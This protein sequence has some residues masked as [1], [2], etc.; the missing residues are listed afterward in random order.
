MPFTKEG[1]VKKGRPKGTLTTGFT[2][3]TDE[4]KK[5]YKS[6]VV[7]KHRAKS[8]PS[9]SATKSSAS[10]PS[11]T[12]RRRTLLQNISPATTEEA[13]QPSSS[14]QG[15]P[16]ISGEKAMTPNTRRGR[17][18]SQ[19]KTRR[20]K[21]KVSSIRS[22]ISKSLWQKDK[23]ENNKLADEYDSS[24]DEGNDDD[25]SDH[26]LSSDDNA[27][28]DSDAQTLHTPPASNENNTHIPAVDSD[29]PGT[30]SSANMKNSVGHAPSTIYRHRSSLRGCLTFNAVDN[31]RILM[32]YVSRFLFITS[33]SDELNKIVIADGHLNERQIRY[34]VKKLND[35]IICPT[36]NDVKLL[37]K[38][39]L[40]LLLEHP[41]IERLFIVAS[42]NIEE[43]LPHSLTVLRKAKTIANDLVTSRSNVKDSIRKTGI[44]FV[45]EV[46]QQCSLS[47]KNARDI[48]TLANA[49]SCSWRFAKKVLNAIESGDTEDLYTRQMKYNA[50]KASEWP[51]EICKFVLSENNSRSVPGQEQVSVR[52]GYRLPKYILLHSR[53]S[54]ADAFKQ[55]F[56][57]CP[58]SA[59]TIMREFPQNA[60]TATTRDLE[61]NTCPVHANARRLINAINKTLVKQKSVDRLPSSCRDLA[62]LTMC[63]SNVNPSKPLSWKSDC[64]RGT[65]KNCPDKLPLSLPTGIQNVEVKYSQWRS[66]K[67]TYTK[68]KKGKVVSIE[69]SVFSLYPETC[70]VQDALL[71]LEK[72]CKPL[73]LHIYTAHRQWNAHNQFRENLDMFTIITIEDYQMNLEVV[74]KENPTS[75]AYSTNKMTVAIYPICVEYRNSDGTISK[76]A[77]TFISDDKDH[78][79]QQVQQFERRMFQIVRERLGR[80]I[81]NWIRFSDGCG[82]QFKSGF[83]AADIFDAPT[84]FDI[85]T[86]AFNFFASHEGKSASDS[87]GS[88]VKCAFVRGMLKNEQGV[89]NID[90]IL[91]VILSETKLS[92]K[93]FDHFIVEKFGRFQKKLP[94]PEDTVK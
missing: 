74:Y 27:V 58:Y 88:I 34:R 22:K 50:I 39:W 9:L 94:L 16:P 13:D 80:P 49:T 7:R 66:E 37:V 31:L 26:D 19:Q 85:N 15:R 61:R 12:K 5:K 21:A 2:D 6:E 67:K 33:F 53:K 42:V 69:K 8:V 1:K 73:R 59:S 38:Y 20:H 51:E 92:T 43:Y 70:S 71:K 18:R 10:N 77:I 52:Y 32:S 24:S 90:D 63:K 11:P 54:I 65:C 47:T 72:M 30:S 68:E 86:V 87:I 55:Q 91:D 76:M 82:A 17:R 75:L 36:E 35:S 62:C 57:N 79:H 4:E 41:P 45:V 28:H 89:C 14:K 25:E 60:V 23:P 84:T 3:M 64:V 44:T 83:V 81:N 29:V 93:K 46:A 40:G 78:S 56:P 48:T